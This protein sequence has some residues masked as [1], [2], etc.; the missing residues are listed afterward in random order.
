MD[1]YGLGLTNQKKNICGVKIKKS[2]FIISKLETC[3]LV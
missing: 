1:K 3:G 2:I